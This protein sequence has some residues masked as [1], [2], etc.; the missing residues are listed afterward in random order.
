MEHKHSVLGTFSTV[1]YSCIFILTRCVDFINLMTY[2]LHLFNWYYPL[3]GHNSPLFNRRKEVGYLATLNMAASAKL[4]VSRGMPK[5][6]IVVGIPTYGLSW[7][8]VH[9]L[10]HG[11]SC[12]TK[13]KGREGGGYVSYPDVCQ[14][15]ANGGK[16]VFDKQCKVPYAFDKKLWISYD[17][18][19]S[20]EAKAK[21]IKS[22]GFAGVMTFSLNCD[23]HAGATSPDN[24]RFPLHRKIKEVVSTNMPA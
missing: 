19:E 3:A 13:G 8:L 16:R 17:D 6:K 12:P 18:V 24:T 14:F 7:R 5:S 10:W 15:L 20:V 1:Y 21:W 4:W 11:I 22:E 2:D 9:R 23:D